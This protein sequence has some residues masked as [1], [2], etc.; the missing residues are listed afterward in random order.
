M[1]VDP[2]LRALVELA[3][4]KAPEGT[5]TGVVL[6][7]NGSMIVGQLAP[8]RAFDKTTI[9]GLRAGMEAS[10]EGQSVSEFRRDEI[11]D[12]ILE[13]VSDSFGRASEDVPEA[14][15]LTLADAVTWVFGQR[16][17]VPAIRVQM[18]EIDA[19]YVVGSNGSTGPVP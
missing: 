15:A 18:S 9:V 17:D 8:D 16:F 2:K 6:L 7:V 19:W 3:Q 11:I 1:P 14:T 13:L 5:G 4:Q 10:L 12:E